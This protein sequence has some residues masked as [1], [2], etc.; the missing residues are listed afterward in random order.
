MA[1]K[2]RGFIRSQKDINRQSVNIATAYA[3][4][5]GAPIA[6]GMIESRITLPAQVEKFLPYIKMAMGLTGSIFFEEKHLASAFQGIGTVGAYEAALKL[7]AEKGVNLNL[8]SLGAAHKPGNIE[9]MFALL[10]Q[11][12]DIEDPVDPKEE[13]EGIVFTEEAEEGDLL[14]N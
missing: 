13:E 9:E 5:I 8:K 12:S 11:G 7:Q 6:M 10:Q 1:K 4:G 2:K 3:A 14:D